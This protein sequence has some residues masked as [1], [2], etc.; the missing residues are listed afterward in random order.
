MHG[1]VLRSALVCLMV[2]CI[3]TQWQPGKLPG[4]DSLRNGLAAS[5]LRHLSRAKPSQES[6]ASLFFTID[7][8]FLDQC[9]PVTPAPRGPDR[10]AGI[11]P[12]SSPGSPDSLGQVEPSRPLTSNHGSLRFFPVCEKDWED[13]RWRL[14]PWKDSCLAEMRHDSCVQ[15]MLQPLLG[16]TGWAGRT[17]QV[18]GIAPLLGQGC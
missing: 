14:G 18:T 5:A 17:G 10:C 16:Q 15:T 3:H 9:I 4:R 7:Y 8:S 2:A 6:W 11:G 13:L 1:S 12:I